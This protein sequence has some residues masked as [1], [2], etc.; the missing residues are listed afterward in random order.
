[1]SMA[2]RPQHVS[3]FD[4]QPQMLEL[5][6]NKAR[7]DSSPASLPTTPRSRFVS[8]PPSPSI[9]ESQSTFGKRMNWGLNSREA[10]KRKDL[11]MRVVTQA[12]QSGWQRPSRLNVVRT[13]QGQRWKERLPESATELLAR[14]YEALIMAK[15]CEVSKVTVTSRREH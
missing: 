13:R 4:Q 1:M 6:Q 5:R 14:L 15:N 7:A 2:I 9:A 8:N 11:K 3:H 12:P 10:K